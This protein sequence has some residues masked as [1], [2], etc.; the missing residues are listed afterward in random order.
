M[1]ELDTG[2]QLKSAIGKDDKNWI[3][4]FPMIVA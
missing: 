3:P 1:N 2:F 4:R